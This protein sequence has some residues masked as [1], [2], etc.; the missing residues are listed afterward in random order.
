MTHEYPEP[1]RSKA[2]RRVRGCIYAEIQPGQILLGL[3][4][5]DAPKAR[6]RK[7]AEKI[8]AIYAFKPLKSPPQRA[9]GAR[10]TEW[11]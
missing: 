2:V 11:Q 7:T 8:P 4:G 5:V 10:L 3:R 9:S 1:R 6:S